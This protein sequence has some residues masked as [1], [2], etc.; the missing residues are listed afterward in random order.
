MDKHGPIPGAY[1]SVK[2][3]E[4][5]T[6]TDWD[7]KF[8]LEVKEGEILLVF[9]PGVGSVEISID[10]KDFFNIFIPDYKPPIS[11]KMKREQRRYLRKNGGIIDG[12]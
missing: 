10:S 6:S 3:T 1:I 12:Y 2:G 8:E 9:F 11:K 7:G 4:R 5:K